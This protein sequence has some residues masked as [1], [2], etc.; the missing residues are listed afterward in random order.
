LRLVQTYKL[1]LIIGYCLLFASIFFPFSS[2]FGYLVVFPNPGP[3]VGPQLASRATFWSFMHV[4]EALAKIEGTWVATS[5]QYLSFAE[6]WDWWGPG[7]GHIL[8]SSILIPMFTLQIIAVPL[9]LATLRKAD[10]AKKIL[11]LPL[12]A[13]ALTCLYFAGNWVLQSELFIGFW[14]SILS[15]ASIMTAVACTRLSMHTPAD[16]SGRV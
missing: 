5:V 11:P 2:E 1:P 9:G 16:T 13:L 10:I 14:L 6:Y 8:P 12:V 15:T 3:Y 7:Q 4:Q